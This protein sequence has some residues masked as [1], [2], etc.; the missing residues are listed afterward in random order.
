MNGKGAIFLDRDGVINENRSDHVKSW[1]EFSFIPGVLGSIRELTAL[2]LPI[3]VITNQAAVNRGLMTI[4][5][6][7]DIHRRMKASIYETGG[8]ITKI[9]YCPHDQHEECNCRKPAAGMLL[10]AAAEYGIDLTKSFL[11]G[12]AWT[13]IAAGVNVGAKSILLMTGRGSWNFV[14]CWHRFGLNFTAACDLADATMMIK[15]ALRGHSTTR[16]E[17]VWGSHSMML[18]AEPSGAF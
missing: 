14:P 12:D 1:N 15:E 8:E 17:Q 11:V 2:G 4:E 3:F 6:L 5:T 9:Y 13:D 18:E 10:Q 7:N 16:G